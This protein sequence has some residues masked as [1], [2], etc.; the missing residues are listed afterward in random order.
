MLGTIPTS[1]G[2]AEWMGPG[3]MFHMFLQL[4]LGLNDLNVPGSRLTW[5]RNMI[6]GN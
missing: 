6:S 2:M 1:G 4:K 5:A 3:S